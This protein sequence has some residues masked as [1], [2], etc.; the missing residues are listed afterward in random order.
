MPKSRNQKLKIPYLIRILTEKTDEEHGLSAEELILELEH[1][2]VQ[3]ERKSIYDDME[4]LRDIYGMD[5]VHDRKT[6]YR[7]ASHD[8]D[9]SELKLLV[10]AVQSSRFIS[11]SKSDELIK[12]LKS[13]TSRHY[14]AELQRQIWVRD[15]IKSMNGSSLYTIETIQNA[16]FHNVK[17]SFQYYRWTSAKQQVARHG[18]RKYT[19]S[20]WMLTWDNEYYYLVAFD[21]RTRQIRHYRVDRM[22]NTTAEKA[23]REG[24]EDFAARDRSE[25]ASGIFGMYS[26]EKAQLKFHCSEDMADVVIDR[27][28]KDVI[29]IPDSNGFVFYAEIDLSPQFY[30]WIASFKDNIRILSPENAV[31]AFQEHLSAA[32][33]QYS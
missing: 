32:L 26:G 33:A 14:A 28:G 7:L 17:I 2:D 8:F 31:R 6:G 10:D 3:A 20:P 1:Y 15:R 4:L 30:G 18:G 23:L 21:D 22:K 5:I 27:F 12:K 25:Y 24:R 29:M 11:A 13:L 9:L 16:M 19:V